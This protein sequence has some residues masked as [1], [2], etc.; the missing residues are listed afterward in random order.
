MNLERKTY[1]HLGM[2]K[3]SKDRLTCPEFI[4]RVAGM[5]RIQV[6]VCVALICF[7]SSAHWVISILNQGVC[8]RG[9]YLWLLLYGILNCTIWKQ[10]TYMLLLPILVGQ[11][12]LITEKLILN[13]LRSNRF[14]ETRVY[15]LLSITVICYFVCFPS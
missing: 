7:L 8:T 14:L 1:P 15:L 6:Q 5:T 13:I 10:W 3:I 11:G 9:R 2:K 12:T 4:Q